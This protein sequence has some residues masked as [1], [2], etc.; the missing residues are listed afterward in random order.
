MEK[1]KQKK[2]LQNP[3][4]NAIYIDSVQWQFLG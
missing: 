4:K 3:T 1:L 2:K